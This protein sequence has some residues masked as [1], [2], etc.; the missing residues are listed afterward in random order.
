MENRCVV[1]TSRPVGVPG[2]EAFAVETR[3]APRPAAGE[4]LVRNRFLSVDPAM[5]GWVNDAP[6]YLP[7]VPVG[8]VMRAFAVGEI[9]ESRHPD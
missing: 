4:F 3:P 6:N 5:R 7:P 1:L 9:V 8:G 2:P